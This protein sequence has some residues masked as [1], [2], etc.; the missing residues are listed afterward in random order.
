[1]TEGSRTNVFAQLRGTLLTPPVSSGLLSGTFRAEMLASGKAK[2]AVLTLDDLAQADTVYLGN[3]VRGLLPAR[4][5]EI[6]AT[7][8][9]VS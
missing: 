1:V 9:A 5:C 3:S 7:R 6:S 2:E 4:A 8:T